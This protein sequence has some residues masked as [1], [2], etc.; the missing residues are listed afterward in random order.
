MRISPYISS[1][2]DLFKNWLLLNFFPQ[3]STSFNE[4][5][6]TGSAAW[7]VD[8]GKLTLTTGATINSAVQ[9]YLWMGNIASLNWN[10]ERRVKFN[11][12]ADYD[13][14]QDII[15]VSGDYSG[16]QYVGFKYINGVLSGISKKTG[17]AEQAV[18]LDA[19]F[20]L[21]S[22]LSFILTAN[23]RVQFFVDGVYKGE[24]TSSI[25][26]GTDDANFLVETRLK[27]TVAANRMME[28]Y[29]VEFLQR[30]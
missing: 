24:I 4:L 15:I 8:Y 1:G 28:L 7:G 26:T 20:F 11:A 14:T 9:V 21:S 19:A 27:N 12:Y 5:V 29:L 30:R 23:T 17:V 25:P 10:F 22:E 6:K 2:R 13:T 3:A 16:N 18:V